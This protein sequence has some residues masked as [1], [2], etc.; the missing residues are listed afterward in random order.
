[1]GMVVLAVFL[2]IILIG[3]RGG[4]V[5][6]SSVVGDGIRLFAVTYLDAP[7]GAGYVMIPFKKNIKE[8]KYANVVVDLNKDGKWRNYGAQGKVQEEWVVQ[9]VPVRVSADEPYSLSFVFNDADAPS[10]TNLKARVV[11]TGRTVEA[12]DVTAGWDGAVPEGAGAKD[13]TISKIAVDEFGDI[14]SPDPTGLTEKYPDE[15]APVSVSYNIPDGGGAGS[16]ETESAYAAAPEDINFQREGV[17][18][19]DQRRNEC[20][21]T[22]TANSLIWLAEKYDF[23][24]KM[25]ATADQVIQELKNDM[26]W[27][28][29][30]DEA[31][32]KYVAG[33]MF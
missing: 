17:P 7:N 14:W 29:H 32:G 3:C 25:P 27:S 31:R 20:V 28:E 23:K 22:S 12:A 33:L 26:N 16:L 13:V 9:N 2:S 11:L 4:S 10:R 5:E 19:I 30:Y 18:D 6:E 24:D 21:P 15:P 8:R 1:M